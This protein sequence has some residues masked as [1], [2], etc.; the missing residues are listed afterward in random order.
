MIVAS[1]FFILRV[2]PGL[3]E[4]TT[5][6]D[7]ARFEREMTLEESL[8]EPDAGLQL[9]QAFTSLRLGK[10]LPPT[11]PEGT[12]MPA[13]A[14][15][16]APPSLGLDMNDADSFAQDEVSVKH[17]RKGPAPSAPEAPAAAPAEE[18]E[19]EFVETAG[20]CALADLAREADRANAKEDGKGERRPGEMDF[21]RPEHLEKALFGELEAA[22]AGTHKGLSKKRMEDLRRDLAGL[23]AALPKNEHG[24]LAPAA[25]RYAVHQHFVR[26]RNWYLRSLNPIGEAQRPPSRAEELRGQVPVH[27]Q[28]LLER[29]LGERGLGHLELTALVATLEHLIRGDSSERLKASYQTYSLSPNATVSSQQLMDV[30]KNFMT[31]YLSLKHRSGYA[32]TRDEAERNLWEVERGYDG[33]RA[34]VHNMEKALTQMTEPFGFKDAM[35]AANKVMQRYEWKSADECHVF[36]RDLAAMPGG[37]TGRVALTVLHQSAL[38]GKLQFSESTEYLTMLGAL[39][40]GKVLIPNYLIGPSQCLGTTSFYD[41]CCPNECESFVE[42]LERRIEKPNPTPDEI[43]AVLG[44]RYGDRPISKDF[45][46]ELRTTV[47]A[48][49]GGVA[50]HGYT[51]AQWLSQVYPLEC[52][53]PIAADYADTALELP[54]AKREFQA[55]ASAHVA[56][57][58]SELFEELNPGRDS[59]AELEAA[60]AERLAEVIGDV[61]AGGLKLKGVMDTASF[62][63][64]SVDAEP[65]GTQA[66]ATEWQGALPHEEA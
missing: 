54:G 61:A 62:A 66:E 23:Y 13:A 14:A 55:V 52:S 8:L 39:Q 6:R 30:L 44:T 22:L 48:R 45:V 58:K 34:V 33:W 36:K 25:V 60:A 7:G 31:H 37:E 65:A 63:Q 51:F 2:F 4:Q 26:T 42:Q 3:A 49:N 56:A 50:L 53:T 18:E 38:S 28:S 20:V 29:H 40:D 21:A 11:G 17:V 15:P 5:L 41:S 27:L 59:D 19:E 64:N 43:I 16:P 9:M 24:R 47:A 12:A 32:V 46:E 35:A 57:S 1:C 10:I